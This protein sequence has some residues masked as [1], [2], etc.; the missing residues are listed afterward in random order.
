[1]KS[2]NHVL[3]YC[4]FFMFTV[5]IP[6]KSEANNV[7]TFITSCLKEYVF[8]FDEVS[9]TKNKTQEKN[10]DESMNKLRER[11]LT[12]EFRK[13]WSTKDIGSDPLLH[14]Q[15]YPPSWKTE[16]HVEKTDLT[17]GQAKVI[18]GNR[19]RPYCLFINLKLVNSTWRIASSKPCTS[20]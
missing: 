9:G 19:N 1:M 4:L 16:V 3:L 12:S 13:Q 7:E 2:I 10:L 11:C 8:L 17:K 14:F 20:N 5:T 15:D 18:F 6:L